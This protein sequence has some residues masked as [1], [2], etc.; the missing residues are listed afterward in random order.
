[1]KPL[2]LTMTAFGPYK[3]T[4][5]V[6]FNDLEQH[7][8]FVISGNTGAGKT[9]IFD[10]IC[11]ALYGSASGTDREDNKML[12]SDFAEDDT[13][14]AIEL[15]FELHGRNYRI[16][17][18]L[19]H[20]KKGNKSKTGERYEFF[21]KVGEKE[22]PCV[23]RQ[24]VSEIDKKVEAILGLTQDQFKQIVMLPQGEFRKLLTSQTENK[25]AILRKLFKTESYNQINQL[26]RDKKNRVEENYRSAKQQ[27]DSYIQSIAASIPAREDSR[28][29]Q[30]LAE[31]HYNVNQ[32]VNGLETEVDH[33]SDRIEIDKQKYD[34]AY[35]AHDKQQTKYHQAKALNERFADL[36]QKTE[37][38][39]R[40]QQQKDSYIEKEKQLEKAERASH[41]EAYERQLTEQK[42]EE[43]QK[44]LALQHGQAA[45]KTAEEQLKQAQTAYEKEAEKKPER[46]EIARKLDQLKSH[47]PAVRNLEERKMELD[48]LVKEGK[49][50]AAQL[51]KAKTDVETKMKESEALERTVNE[52]DE[53]VDRLSDK[54]QELNEVKEQAKVVQTYLK[55]RDELTKLAQD[56]ESKKED[57]LNIQAT[58]KQ[59]EEVWLNNQAAVLA[60]HLHDGHPCPVCG[61]PEHPDKAVS[62]GET[63]TRDQLD[64]LKKQRDEKENIYKAADISCQS[65]QHQLTEKEEELA[66]YDMQPANA[67][68]K[69]NQ[70]FETGIRLKKEVEKL[71]EQR[72]ELKKN[73][74]RREKVKEELKQLEEL[75]KTYDKKRQE[76]RTGYQS[77]K[78]VYDNILENIPEEVRVLKQLNKQ[79][80]ETNRQ[81]QE[82]E[83]AWEEAQK[84]LQE[85]KEA[86]TRTA[87]S[88]EH[89]ERQLEEAREKLDK[90]MQQFIERITMEGFQSEEA[91]RAAKMPESERKQEK[92]AIRQFRENLSAKMQTVKDLQ[93]ELQEKER[94]D[95]TALAEQL[96]N[97]KSAY[98]AALKTLEDSREYR[99][100]AVSLKENII[101]SSQEVAKR[102]KE[103]ATITDLH[104][105]LRGQNERKISFERYLQIEYL[106]RIIEAANSRLNRLSNGQFHLMRSDRQEAHG[107]Q[108]GLALDVYDA[109][110][111]QTRDVKTLSGGEK[112]NASL[113][114]AL[115]MSDVIQ[116]FQGSISIDTMFIDEGFGSLDEES[117][118]KSIDTLIELQQSGRMIGVISHVQ[119]LKAV[120]PAVLQ[121]A[122]T[123]EGHSRTKFIVK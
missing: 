109:Y 96:Q 63:V 66:H 48:K 69:K 53:S 117:L 7:N 43:Q 108:S 29:F 101:G 100:K 86:R 114:L 79:I 61:S 98:E 75:E 60:E 119:E 21:E 71:L 91:Y 45:D 26:L 116:S 82:L 46:E 64:V 37:E 93:A 113:C 23:D 123:K 30:V 18:Q 88:L 20:V 34:E 67:L 83:Q 41:L 16:L 6:D 110:T 81:K 42:K 105:V 17:R 28:L 38:L 112:F 68:S 72:E 89:A 99:K 11:F 73:K 84:S 102:E 57:F 122:K 31:P 40:L 44:K 2:K 58:Y 107:R 103:L 90:A 78:A 87:S 39:E 13:H 95:L 77:K 4:E 9:T 76:Q 120:F 97:L 121:V 5:C 115:G 54:Q 8:L 19:G 74:E 106:E 59:R 51:E 10:G 65:K 85:K 56:L 118:N 94:T 111:G 80:E 3:Q 22:V 36:D 14:T 52:M 55:Y 49:E 33:Y 24:I 50:T 62:H 70:L 27:S 32:V 47:L 15:E 35:H 104:D 1:M 92:E 25:E 12:R